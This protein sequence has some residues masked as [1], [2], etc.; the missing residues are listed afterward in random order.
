MNILEPTFHWINEILANIMGHFGSDVIKDFFN[1]VF[2]KK[3]EETVREQWDYIQYG[4]TKK[5]PAR[6]K[7]IYQ[8]A[9]AEIQR[10]DPVETRLLRV[11]LSDPNKYTD[12]DQD[13]FM[14]TAM[15][16]GDDPDD[17][18]EALRL[19]IPMLRTYAQMPGDEFDYEMNN[20]NIKLAPK[21]AILRRFINF[22][23]SDVQAFIKALYAGGKVTAQDLYTASK[24]ISRDAWNNVLKPVLSE[25]DHGIETITDG[26]DELRQR[27]HDNAA[28][29]NRRKAARSGFRKF[30]GI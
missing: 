30:F 20:L 26:A 14:L 25:L 7:D 21:E 18:N 2:V 22:I 16:Y 28:D 4:I 29:F 1:R 23:G 17:M 13:R 27:M 19:T 8:R 12:A 3:G 6:V 9:M 5:V 10:T 24:T 15:Q 11:R